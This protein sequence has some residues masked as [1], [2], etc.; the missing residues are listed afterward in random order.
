MVGADPNSCSGAACDVTIEA[1]ITP[2][3]V[4]IGGL[5]FSGTDVLAATLASPQFANERLRLDDRRDRGRRVPERSGAD[6]RAG[7]RAVAGR[8][9]QS[10]PARGR[11][12]AG[13]VQQDG[14]EHLPRP[15]APER[16]A[17]GHDQ[18]AAA[19]RACCSQSGRGVIFA[20]VNISWWAAQIKNLET[21]ADP[22]HLPIYLTNN[23]LL[24]IGKDVIQLLRDRLPRHT[25]DGPRQRQRRTRTATRR[26]RR[27]PGPRGSSR[28]STRGRTAAPTGRCRT[29]TRSATRSPSGPTTR[30]STTRSS[31][32]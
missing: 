8:R 9:G 3:N 24:H 25:G 26:C 17:G 18:R 16:A 7:R 23:V 12:D 6:P 20:D 31:R 29:S 10:A 13:P 21:T 30:S 28:A 4:N 22:T 19:T 32:G 15:S 5:T 27:S 11:D 14:R 2:I 1:D